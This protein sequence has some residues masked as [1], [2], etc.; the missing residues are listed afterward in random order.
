[1]AVPTSATAQTLVFEGALLITGED[2]PP[3]EDSVF[4]AENG[5]FI[6]VGKRDE[7]NLDP[8]TTRINLDGK[9]VVPAFID[10]HSHI[11]YMHEL[12]S[13]PQY[14]TRA[15]ILDHMHRFAWYGV[16]ASMAWGTDFGELPFQI[17]DETVDGL[18]PAAARFLTAGRGLAPADEIRPDNM[19]HSAWLIENQA[20]IFP[21]VAD[22]V[23]NRV[24]L[25]KTW[26]DDR[27]G[28]VRKFTPAIYQAIID[29]A[30]RSGLRVVV[31]AT[32]L[33]DVKS[34]LRAGV[35]G[36]AHMPAEVDEELMALLA[37]RPEVFFTL[38]LGAPRR[39]VTAPW[40]DPVHPL[41][42]ATAPPS[43]LARLQA[44]LT[45][46]SSE[47][48]AEAQATWDKLASGI[49][50][51]A[52]A[53]VKIGVGTDGGG[54][55]GDQFIGW[56]MHT[57]MEN[58]VAAGMSPAQVLIAATRVSAGIVGLQHE[59][60]TV[61]VGKSADFVVLD[62]NPLEDITNTRSIARVYLRGQE[63][64]RGAMQAAWQR[65]YE[66]SAP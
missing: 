50:R 39:N 35:D 36:F 37:E 52:E 63:I 53:R 42:A 55:Q 21:A 48:R 44:R 11:G 56:T 34:L 29:E 6:A 14:Y 20:D 27:G 2:G 10:A 32:G 9:T 5:R 13:G 3:L 58:M 64:P 43:Q 15:N 26:V 17:R 66:Q 31:H 16:A 41:L 65:A 46:M 8:G 23:A 57:E 18:Y 45:G 24:P 19:R 12:D 7:I 30:H 38:A 47:A 22:L 1:A 61:A 59:L 33:Q 40:L 25:L 62:A 60:G 4:V 54:Q 51:L 49:R 28:Q